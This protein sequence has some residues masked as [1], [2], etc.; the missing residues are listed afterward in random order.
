M[1]YAHLLNPD[2]AL[3]FRITHVAN[4]PWILENGLH[5]RSSGCQDPDFVNIG[6]EDLIRKRA[7][8]QV[9]MPPGG[10]LN[11]YVPFYFTP[12]SPMFLNI[13]T[14]WGDIRCRENRDIAILVTSLPILESQDIGYLVSDRHAKLETAEFIAGRNGLDTFLAWEYLQARDFK[15]NPEIP[16]KSERYQAEALIFKHL[17][18][19]AVQGI[20]FY[21]LEAASAFQPLRTQ[22]GLDLEI[23][24]KPDWYFQ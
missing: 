2:R 5:C 8:R 21:N 10:T 7:L 15:K 4:I 1:S 20:I 18:I 6:N 22:L 23:V 9:P 11:D 3:I 12:F 14:G 17:P 16:D 24:T 19:C 13:H